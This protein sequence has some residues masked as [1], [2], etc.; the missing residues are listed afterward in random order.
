MEYELYHYGILGMHWGVRR[1][2][3]PDGTYTSAGKK[4]YATEN[5]DRRKPLSS[6]AVAK[7][8]QTAARDA[9]AIEKK[10]RKLDA[11]GDKNS[12]YRKSLENSRKQLTKNLSKT[13][14]EYGRAACTA[15]RTSLGLFAAGTVIGTPLFGAALAAGYQMFGE[16]PNKARILKRNVSNF[17]KKR[18]TKSE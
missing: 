14:I 15:R 13:D 18:S 12:E 10:L 17:E 16:N 5:S 9:A 6:K 1:Y 8:K 3:N 11:K 7:K 4:R 2:Q